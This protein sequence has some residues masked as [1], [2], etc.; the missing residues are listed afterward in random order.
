MQQKS[1]IWVMHH[2][3]QTSYTAREVREREIVM[4]WEFILLRII[5]LMITAAFAAVLLLV[6]YALL[7]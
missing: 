6:L 1:L 2:S 7:D 3:A 5:L 4:D